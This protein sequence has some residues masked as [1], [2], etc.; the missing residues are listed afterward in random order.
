MAQP[1]LK[2]VGPAEAQPARSPATLASLC[3]SVD[4]LEVVVAPRGLDVP[5][6]GLS[7]HDPL[8]PAPPA[9]G[10][11]VLA[12]GAPAREQA[13]DDLVAAVREAAAAGVVVRRRRTLSGWLLDAFADAGVALLTAPAD[14][15]WADLH[16]LL[17][18]ALEPGGDRAPAGGLAGLADATAALAGGPVT[19]E[20]LEGRVLAFSQGGQDVDAARAATVLGR[21]TPD[22]WLRDLRRSG[23]LDRIVHARDAVTVELP[24]LAPRRAAAIRG[25]GATLG[26]VWLVGGDPAAGAA[27]RDAARAAAVQ[28]LREQAGEDLE[29]RVRA[30]ALRMLLA[31]EG[32]PQPML[33][34]LGLPAEDALAVVAVRPDGPA[35]QRELQRH[36]DLLCAH[37]RADRLAAAA[38]VLDGH[39]YAVVALPGATAEATVRRAVTDWL[40]RSTAALHAGLGEPAGADVL[41]SARRAAD[42]C[43]ELSG[44]PGELVAYDAVHGRAL[45][46][47]VATLLDGESP[48]VRALRTYD[49]ERGTDYIAT[50]CA[51]LDVHG[52]AGRTATAL[53]IHVNTLRYRMRRLEEIAG[54]DLDDAEARLAIALELHALAQRRAAPGVTSPIS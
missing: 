8:D 51:F 45:L 30:G 20:D 19:I 38:G 28:L 14:L 44:A 12:P 52:D 29:R 11:L 48:A 13:T 46:A 17:L 50:L 15:P 42:R 53:G 18:T 32:V 23:A 27:L 34:A 49:E 41:A 3:D 31:G 9:R 40:Q 6:A 16:V 43:I 47:D 25:A 54:L 7:I 35:T 4:L 10:D 2:L 33:A 5:V 24:G 36:A 21:R 1:Q 39:V 22:R 37:L 26:V